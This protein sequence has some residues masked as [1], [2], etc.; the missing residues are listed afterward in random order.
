MSKEIH[1]ETFREECHY[2]SKRVLILLLSVY[3]FVFFGT[4]HRISIFQSTYHIY[5]QYIA[6]S[7]A[8]S[9]NFFTGRNNCGSKI[10]LLWTVADYAQFINPNTKENVKCGKYQ[11]ILTSDRSVLNVSHAV[12]FV[13]R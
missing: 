4:I 2:I 8:H 13:H 3:C 6:D 1:A 11:C 9:R 5:A 7:S 10:I 12:Y